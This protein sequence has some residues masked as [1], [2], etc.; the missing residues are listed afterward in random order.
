MRAILS[1]TRR[2]GYTLTSADEPRILYHSRTGLTPDRSKA[3]RF[4]TLDHAVKAARKHYSPRLAHFNTP[5][6]TYLSRDL[7]AWNA[8]TIEESQS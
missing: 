7:R 4:K 3:T 8:Q 6:G 2:E 1:V 5:E